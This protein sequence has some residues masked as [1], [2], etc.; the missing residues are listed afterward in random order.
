MNEQMIVSNLLNDPRQV[1][2]LEVKS[3][4]FTSDAMKIIVQAVVDLNGEIKNMTD[5]SEQTIENGNRVG[6]EELETLKSAHGSEKFSFSA[7]VPYLHK[8]FVQ[9]QL[10]T[11]MA[12]YQLDGR[13]K[14]LN[15]IS[16]LT[17]EIQNIST[18][19]DD[20]LLSSS[21]DE[22]EKELFSEKST[23]LRTYENI[24][25]MI[26]G[27]YRP[28]QLITVGARSGVGKTLVSLNFMMD[29]LERNKNVRAD[30]F[31]LEMSKFEIV[32]RIISKKDNINSLK[33][34]DYTNLNSKEKSRVFNSYKDLMNNY[35]IGLF[36]EEYS[37]LGMI[38]RKIKERAIAGKYIVFIDYVGLVAVEGVK[39]GGDSAERI[40]INL[41][42]RELKLLAAELKIPIFILA[43]LNRGLEY[44]QDKTPGLQDLKASGSLEQDSNIVMFVS[45]DN[46]EENLAYLDIA[47]N[48][49]GRCGR[50]EF[51][52]NPAFMEFTPYGR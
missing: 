44:R 32:N 31:S 50:L 18:R 12:K 13:K 17:D 40:A 16:E 5:V 24:N 28:G 1:Q 2:F 11:Y 48:R 51:Y 46:E 4:W 22:F 19:T 15:I 49:S 33:L 27:G 23:S 34:V 3:E 20:G 41:I 9:K 37:T 42:T 30:F 52:M 8:N 35:D 29:I 36:G 38:K 47:K 43:Q 45:K 25:K 7:M 6:L 10:N 39:A 14:Y 21:I 26:G